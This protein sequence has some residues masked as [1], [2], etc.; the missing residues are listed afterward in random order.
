[1][2]SWEDLL[3]GLL[4]PLLVDHLAFTSSGFRTLG[5]VVCASTRLANFEHVAGGRTAHN[6][7]TIRHLAETALAYYQTRRVGSRAPSLSQAAWL[8]T[9]DPVALGNF[10]GEKRSRGLRAAALDSRSS[11]TWPS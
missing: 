7:M 4:F 11:I 9:L 6:A 2:A 1:M 5:R 3:A 10:D 8:A